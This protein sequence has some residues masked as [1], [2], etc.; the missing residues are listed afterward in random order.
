MERVLVTGATGFIGIEVSRQ[1]AKLGKR[2]RLMVRRPVRGLML[3]SLDAEIMQADIRSPKSLRR[4]LDGADTVIHLGA[5][6]AFEPYSRLYPSIVEG[7]LNLMQA[8]IDARVTNFVFGG[9]LMVYGDSA[10]P[11]DQNTGPSPMSGYGQAKFEAERN[12]KKWPE[13][14]V[15]VLFLCAYRMSMGLT[16]CFSTR[17][18][19]AGFSSQDEATIPLRTYMSSTPHVLSSKPL[20][21]VDQVPGWWLMT[22]RVRG[23]IFLRRLKHTTR[24]FASRTFLKKYLTWE[25]DFW[26]SS[27]K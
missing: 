25:H 13:T 20:R 24:D 5:R 23:M 19:T 4:I 14:A 1:L 6:A 12:S 7:S 3:R 22:Y 26:I 10:G 16:A 11:M 8:A 15:S 9:S 27:I 18:G 17:S 2:P 21:T